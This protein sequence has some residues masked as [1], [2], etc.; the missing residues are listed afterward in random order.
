MIRACP[1]TSICRIVGILTKLTITECYASSFGTVSV[2]VERAI[3]CALSSQILSKPARITKI[4]TSPIPLITIVIEIIK[5]K[6]PIHTRLRNIIGKIAS[7]A[8][9][10]TIPR[11]IIRIII[12]G[13]IAD[14]H[15]F[16]TGII[17]ESSR[18]GP[19]GTK[20][21]ASPG[22]I[23]GVVVRIAWAF[24]YAG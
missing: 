13:K 14:G 24:C 15:T 3:A 12:S 22:R 10:Q 16:S 8:N 4:F 2:L 5:P 11:T 21:H 9:R 1:H 23:I 17:G 20:W 7:R 18:H 6:A 19:V